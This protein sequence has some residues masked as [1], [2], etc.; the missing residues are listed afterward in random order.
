MFT[1]ELGML[2]VCG[3]QLGVLGPAYLS[4]LPSVGKAVCEGVGRG[5][6]GIGT[7]RHCEH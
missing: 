2:L 3:I 4:V 6:V 5:E 7:D 1:R